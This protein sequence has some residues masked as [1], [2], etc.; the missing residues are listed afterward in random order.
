MGKDLYIK[1]S[2]KEQ[3]Q[4]EQKER[5]AIEKYLGGI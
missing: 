4:E 3:Q 5:E 1:M 2:D